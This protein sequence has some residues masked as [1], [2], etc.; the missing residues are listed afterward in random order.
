MMLLNDNI[1]YMKTSLVKSIDSNDDEDINL[2][3]V[4]NINTPLRTDAFDLTNNEKIDKISHHFHEIMHT[5]GLDLTDSSL[6][7]TPKRVA[8]MYVNEIFKGLDQRNK[9]SISLFENNYQY[10]QILLERNITIYS[11]CE[12]HF[13]PIIGKAHIAYIPNKHVIG[14]SK[15]NRIAQYFS[16]RPQVQERLTEQIAFELKKILKTQDVAVIIEADH[17]CVSSRGI[18][19][20]SSDTITYHLGGKFNEENKKVEL[21]SL[22]H[23]K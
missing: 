16:K 21:F 14:L 17:L 18:G 4:F 13:V 3:N 22:L 15:L 8:K 1:Y 11:Y 20:T 23:K 5:L 6:K 7:D 19:D 12:H 10:Q 9:P 2:H